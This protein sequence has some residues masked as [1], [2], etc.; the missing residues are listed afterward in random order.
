MEGG[1]G[2]LRTQN[3]SHNLA[4]YLLLDLRLFAV[5]TLK[6]YLRIYS[7]LHEERHSQ[8]TLLK[9]LTLP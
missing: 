2:H 8:L 9:N 7:Q 1:E 6:Q 3:A 4:F 5:Y